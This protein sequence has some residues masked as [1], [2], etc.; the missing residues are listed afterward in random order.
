MTG[1]PTDQPTNQPNNREVNKEVI[2]PI[3]T[4][5][6]LQRRERPKGD[7]PLVPPTSAS[8]VASG[9]MHER[10]WLRQR[11]LCRTL[12]FVTASLRRQKR[13]CERRQREAV[14]EAAARGSAEAAPSGEWV[15]CNKRFDKGMEVELNNDRRIIFPTN[16]PT[17]WHKG[18]DTLPIMNSN[19]RLFLE[20][21]SFIII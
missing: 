18:S 16:Q 17:A 15:I 1:W 19:K 20:N 4:H 7:L 5:I 8:F 2:L 11:S 13:Q 14:Q 3:T 6:T 10:W 12:C 9:R 21:F